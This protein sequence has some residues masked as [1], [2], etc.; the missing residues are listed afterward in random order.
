[1]LTRTVVLIAELPLFRWVVTLVSQV[2][3]VTEVVRG[4]RSCRAWEEH[5][6]QASS[7]ACALQYEP[8]GRFATLEAVVDHYSKD[9]KPHPNLDGRLR[10]RFNFSDGEKAALVVFLKTLSDP[11]FVTDPR[12]SDPFQ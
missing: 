5:Y 7:Y 9:V 6:L 4:W 8:V 10:R 1:M 3:R 12:F 11:K 2:R